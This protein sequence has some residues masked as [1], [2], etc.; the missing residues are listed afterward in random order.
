VNLLESLYA[1]N[2]KGILI[3]LAP[4]PSTPEKI[5]RE[6]FEREDLEINRGL[7]ANASVPMELLDSL[8][9]DTRLQ[10]ELAENPVFIKEY[11]Q[12]LDYDKKAVQF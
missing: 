9:I 11:E 10:N 3:S 6:L 7:A 12:T 1:K 8:K 2:R 4:N 5:L